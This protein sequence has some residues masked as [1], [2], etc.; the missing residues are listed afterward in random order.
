MFLLLQFRFDV[1]KSQRDLLHVERVQFEGR[2]VGGR[3]RRGIRRLLR[4]HDVDGGSHHH[5]ELHV[6]SGEEVI[7]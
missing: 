4:V 5:A 1:W 2:D 6:P 3:L 7:R